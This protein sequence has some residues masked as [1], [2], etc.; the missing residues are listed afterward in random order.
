MYDCRIASWTFPSDLEH[1]VLG[2]FGVLGNQ[3]AKIQTSAVHLARDVPF[4]KV[5]VL[6][7]SPAEWRNNA[8]SS[9]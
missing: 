1:P 7:T 8:L 3:A 5:P 2:V 9:Q 6:V 4:I